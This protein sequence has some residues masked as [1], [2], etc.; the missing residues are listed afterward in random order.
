AIGLAEPRYALALR[1]A[2]VAA[3]QAGLDT[4]VRG[5]P[6][7]GVLVF[8]DT[9]ST[10]A[11]ARAGAAASLPVSHVEAG[12][13]SGDLEMPEGRNRIEV[14]T[15]AAPLFAPDEGSRGILPSARGEGG[16]H[17]VGGV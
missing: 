10:V 9:N 11:G 6:L 8:G 13:R 3:I 12:L 16:I 1:T 4:V 15:I 7:D 2:E 17:G 5:E 14:D